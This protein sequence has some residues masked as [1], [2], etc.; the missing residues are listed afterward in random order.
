MV[1][2][3]VILRERN[4]QAK[5]KHQNVA[6]ARTRATQ[7][8]DETIMGRGIEKL[9]DYRALYFFTPVRRD[10][11]SVL[12]FGGP[13]PSLILECGTCATTIPG[14][15]YEA[16]ANRKRNRCDPSRRRY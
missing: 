5:L 14:D 3:P 16:I 9:H 2:T 4:I 6:S 11:L 8:A 10:V 12:A 7:I 15:N 13:A 1:I